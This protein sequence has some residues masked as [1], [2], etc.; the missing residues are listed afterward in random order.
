MHAPLTTSTAPR[1]GDIGQP[2]RHIE[3]EPMPAAEPVHEPTPA[4]AP[5]REPVPA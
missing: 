1:L 3:F 4:T 2:Q 5:T